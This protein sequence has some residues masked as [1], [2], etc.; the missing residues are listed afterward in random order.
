MRLRYRIPGFG[1]AAGLLSSGSSST[2]AVAVLALCPVSVLATAIPAK[3]QA[4]LVC[5]SWIG[6][7]AVTASAALAS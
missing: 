3:G 1:M 7:D 5:A 2:W 6:N 4:G